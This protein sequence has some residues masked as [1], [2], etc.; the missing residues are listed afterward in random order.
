MLSR[1]GM[2]SEARHSGAARPKHR[3]FVIEGPAQEIAM[4]RPPG[5]Q[6][7]D[8]FG[9]FFGRSAVANE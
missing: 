8:L 6:R 5:Q 7:L 9:G 1:G 2:L 4:S 3:G